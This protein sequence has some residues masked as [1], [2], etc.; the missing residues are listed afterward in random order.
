MQI[1]ID[2][3]QKMNSGLHLISINVITLPSIIR[4][5]AFTANYEISNSL[6]IG[7][8]KRLMFGLHGSHATP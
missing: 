3:G 7:E 6:D 1:I 2:R 4:E 8:E 5:F